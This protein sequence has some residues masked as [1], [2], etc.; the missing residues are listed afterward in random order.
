MAIDPKK[1]TE[2]RKAERDAMNPKQRRIRALEDIADTLEAIR[3][4]FVVW[5]NQPARR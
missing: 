4:Q 1:I 3:A 2:A 5:A